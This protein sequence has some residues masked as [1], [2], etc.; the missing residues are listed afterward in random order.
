M[1]PGFVK[2]GG[3]KGVYSGVMAAASGSAPGSALFFATYETT[4]SL[5]HEVH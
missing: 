2:S 3:F 4:K 5:F 1:S